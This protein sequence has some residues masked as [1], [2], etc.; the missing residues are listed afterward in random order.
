MR[1]HADFGRHPLTAW[2]KWTK[3]VN[4]LVM[5]C[6]NKSDPS[7]RGYRKRMM[8]IWGEIGVFN[9]REQSLAD[10]SRVIRTDELLSKV[11]LEEI[12]REVE[13]EKQPEEVKNATEDR[14]RNDEVEIEDERE[15]DGES[16]M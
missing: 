11:E 8:N 4:K 6:F 9:I 3:E 7:K 16:I 5:K 14:R 13:R 12:Q 1:T 2:K 15:G 10:Q